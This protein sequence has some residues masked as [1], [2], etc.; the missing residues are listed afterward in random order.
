MKP[1]LD[2]QSPPQLW[3]MAGGRQNKRPFFRS[4]DET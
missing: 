4:S 1:I 2:A 3:L